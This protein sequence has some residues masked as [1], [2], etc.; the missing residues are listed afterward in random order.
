MPRGKRKNEKEEEEEKGS[1]RESEANTQLMARL[2]A[3]LEEY[4][5]E[6]EQRCLHM[7][8]QA[9]HLAFALKNTLQM[10]LMKLPKRTRAMPLH[11]FL[12]EYTGDQPPLAPRPNGAVNAS[13]MAPTPA[14]P[15]QAKITFK[16]E[17]GA[18]VDLD[19]STVGSMDAQTKEATK[20]R[21]LSLQSEMHSIMAA[22]R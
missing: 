18:T 2:S 10:E 9:E 19:A 17:N 1:E 4:D 20:A 22:L 6:V 8:T 15:Q 7:Q 12:K 13:I 11:Q 3:L 5:L 16:L 21:L 14:K